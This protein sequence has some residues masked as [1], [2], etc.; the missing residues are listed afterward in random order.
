MW[1][2]AYLDKDARYCAITVLRGDHYTQDNLTMYTLLKECIMDCPAWTFIRRFEKNKDGR[3]AFKALKTQYEGSSSILMRKNAT[4]SSLSTCIFEGSTRHYSFQNYV[5]LHQKAH[6]K[7][8]ELGEPV[9][10]TK[11]VAEFLKY[12]T[13]PTLLEMGMQIVMGDPV[14]LDNFELCQQY[15]STLQT[16]TEQQRRNKRNISGVSGESQ[17]STKKPK[18]RYYS[19]EEWHELGS[20]GRD[21]VNVLRSERGRAQG[22]RGDGRGGRGGRTA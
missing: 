9:S 16:N 15:L 11:K 14:K 20:A 5:T 19:L 12:I 7:L 22:E 1:A 2:E 18:D 13:D 8:E 17:G 21:A 3:G 4:Y 10:K 6:K